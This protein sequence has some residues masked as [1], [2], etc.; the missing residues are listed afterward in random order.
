MPGGDDAARVIVGRPGA[1]KTRHLKELRRRLEEGGSCDLV[2]LDFGPPSLTSVIRIAGEVELRPPAERVDIWRKLWKRAIVR[3]VASYLLDEAGGAECAAIAALRVQRGYLLGSAAGA[4]S[5]SSEFD[6]ILNEN[7]SLPQLLDFLDNSDWREIEAALGEALSKRTKP[8]CYF[9]DIIEDDSTFAPL[10]WLWCIKGLLG[11]VI[12][13][14]LEPLGA[15]D[16]LRIYLAIR[17]QTWITLAKMM[18]TVEQHPN[19]RVLRWDPP[20]LL[21]FFANKIEHLPDCYRM[22]NVDLDGSP[23]DVIAAWL[24]ASTI[25]NKVRSTEELMP[26]YILRHTRLIPRDIV[27][28]G[29]ALTREVYVARHKGDDCVDPGNI[30]LAVANAAL[31]AG[32][33]ELHWCALEIVSARLAQARTTKERN[34]ILPD[35]DAVGHVADQLGD[36][37]SSC[38]GDVILDEELDEVAVEANAGFAGSIDIKSLLWRHGLIGWGPELAGPFRFSYRFGLFGREAPPPQDMHVAMHPVLIDAV[39]VRPSGPEPV[40]PFTGVQE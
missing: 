19:V 21:A 1:G 33:E 8:L 4:R 11:Q 24:G 30:Q 12:R 5:I 32:R 22:P 36:L 9:L 26:A 18:P 25:E 10:Y 3:A 40:D 13:F 20:A 7:G 31:A 17:E 34:V 6:Q 23:Q 39:G 29:N 2:P 28:I 38:S 27:A 14:I 37:L 15:T 35:E 16:K